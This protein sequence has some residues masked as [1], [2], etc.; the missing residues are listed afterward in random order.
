M[1]NFDESFEKAYLQ[2]EKLVGF[3]RVSGKRTVIYDDEVGRHIQ[4]QRN[5]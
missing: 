3:D 1:E 5:L 4:F 2:K